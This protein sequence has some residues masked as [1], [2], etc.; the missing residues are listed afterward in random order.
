MEDNQK[1][2]VD[3]KSNN[4]PTQDAIPGNSEQPKEIKK[5]EEKKE[6][7][8]EQEKEQGKDTNIETQKLIENTTKKD[9]ENLNSISN[10][11]KNK[12]HRRGKNETSGQRTYKCPDCDKSYLSGPALV[13]HRKNKHDFNTE[14]EKKSRGRPKK[15]ELQENAY[16]DTSICHPSRQSQS[17]GLSRKNAPKVSRYY[18]DPG[19]Q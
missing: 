8:K 16:Q 14:A 11:E 2:N 18:M 10:N 15:E 7:E 4:P 3:P 12:R 17:T 13:I 6:S 5:E 9:T 19:I 1:S